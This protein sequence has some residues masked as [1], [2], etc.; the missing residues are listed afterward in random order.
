LH[1]D[2]ASNLNSDVVTTRE[3]PLTSGNVNEAADLIHHS[4][5]TPELHGCD[6]V[7]ACRELLD[8]GSM[9]GDLIDLVAPDGESRVIAIGG[10]V[11]VPS[12][13]PA[14]AREQ[15]RPGLAERVLCSR[16]ASAQVTLNRREIETANAQDGLS[17]V[18]LLHNWID[19][20]SDEVAVEVRR[21]LMVG[22]LRDVQGFKLIEVL[23]EGRESE[24]K[25]VLAGGFRVRSDYADWYAE[26][27]EPQPRRL[28]VGMARDEVPASEG[29]L[30]S[31]VFNYT[32]PRFGFTA[33]QRKLLSHAV[34]HKTDSEIAAALGVSL[35]AVKK[36]WAAIFDRVSDDFPEMDNA[37]ATTG[38]S[39][40][41][42]GA[43]KRHRLLTYLQNHPEELKP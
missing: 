19:A 30:L 7:E 4:L 18:V 12:R 8:A 5:F 2:Q 39:P 11:F 40:A 14:A 9:M 28:L 33:S 21:H 31:L 20:L 24:L 32:P 34:Q 37:R 10:G 35:S 25:W 36:T 15:P 29:S 17:L 6:P 13:V 42:R 38:R 41:T 23:A 27:S 26:H 16:V 1:P 3:R 22:F 43:Q